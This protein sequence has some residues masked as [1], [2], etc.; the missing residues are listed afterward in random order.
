[1]LVRILDL[2]LFSFLIFIS[3]FYYFMHIL[4]PFMWDFVPHSK[5][6]G[7]KEGGE[8]LRVNIVMKMYPTARLTV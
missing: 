6:D 1:M 3:K 4:L 7:V 2:F 5:I 8:S